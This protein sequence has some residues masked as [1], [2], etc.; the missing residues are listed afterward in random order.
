M[1]VFGSLVL[2]GSPSV[3]SLPRGSMW[4]P[5]WINSR[6]KE[7]H[8]GSDGKK[9]CIWALSLCAL[10]RLT[11]CAYTGLRSSARAGFL[12]VSVFVFVS[13]ELVKECTCDWVQIAYKSGPLTVHKHVTPTV[14][15]PPPL[16]LA[17]LASSPARASAHRHRDPAL[18]KCA[19]PET[20]SSC[21]F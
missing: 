19:C 4:N 15:P 11:V 13:I 10:I 8:G 14:Q 17:H 1:F 9:L 6:E 12:C 5:V 3:L 20:S 18:A 2:F 21:S 7:S 16:I